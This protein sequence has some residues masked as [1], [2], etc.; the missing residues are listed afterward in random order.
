MES[1]SLRIEKAYDFADNK[2]APP[3]FR[4]GFLIDE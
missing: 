2:K 1:W 3:K 4:Q